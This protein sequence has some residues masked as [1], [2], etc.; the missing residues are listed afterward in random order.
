MLVISYISI[1]LE[2]NTILKYITNDLFR[3]PAFILSISCPIFVNE[4]IGLVIVSLIP[5]RFWNPNLCP[6]EAF[7]M[8]QDVSVNFP[9]ELFC[10]KLFCDGK[11]WVNRCIGFA[12]LKVSTG[13]INYINYINIF[14]TFQICFG[15]SIIHHSV[16]I[17]CMPCI[18][19][20]IPSV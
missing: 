15:A 17:F 16:S 2:K 9:V 12:L 4:N 18:F 5:V 6:S 8:I 20:S 19:N 3:T 7:M 14:R 10:F 13:N 1:L 11:S